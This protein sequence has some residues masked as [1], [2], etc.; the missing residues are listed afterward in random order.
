MKMILRILALTL[1]LS[2]GRAYSQSTRL[3]DWT[4]VAQSVDVS[5]NAGYDFR[6]TAAI[7]LDKG[8]KNSVGSLWARVDK[9]DGTNGF[10]LNASE[11][12]K[13]TPEWKTY[14][15]EGTIDANAAMLNFGAYC[16]GGGDFYYDDFVLEVKKSHGKWTK[17]PLVNSGFEEKTPH[18]DAWKQ[19]IHPAVPFTVKGFSVA[20]STN[21]PRKGRRALL[22]SGETLLGSHT[23]GK[24][25]EV[26]GASLYYE[27]YGEGEPLLMLHGN[28]GSMSAFLNQVDFF[29]KKYKV[30]LVDC[31]ARG[32]SSYPPG[33]KLSFDLLAD[34]T[35]QFLD[36]IGVP[37]AHILGWS[38]GGII[39]LVMAL[40]YP[41]KVGKLIA[42]GAN[43]FPEGCIDLDGMKQ[44][45]ADWEKKNQDHRYDWY[46]DLYNLDINFPQM[47]YDDLKGIK[48]KTLIMAGDHDVI[49]GEHTL[50]MYEAIR[51]AQLAILPDSTHFVV[52]ENPELFNATVMRFL[53]ED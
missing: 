45:V 23:D 8:K 41:E 50:K 30:I 17:V 46:I 13:A 39:G 38:D 3:Q 9:Q 53:T 5:Q 34:D 31:R 40:R 43:I 28:G 51:G 29:S 15:I 22:I 21:N 37:K 35:A 6:I 2:V 33:V 14:Q 19:G 47:K 1:V 27:I 49:R 26:N 36:K 16:Q 48:S 25:A 52:Q 32:N 42:M 18:D 10:F 20:Y 24:F 11:I 4:S 44:L 7:R 12:V